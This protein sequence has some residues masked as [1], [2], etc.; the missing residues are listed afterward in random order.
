MGRILKKLFSSLGRYFKKSKKK[1]V[2]LKPKKKFTLR[3]KSKK[4]QKLPARDQGALIGEVTHFFNKIQVIVVKMTRDNLRVGDK[5]RIQGKTTDF[6][7]VVKSLQ[8]ESV[9]VKLVKK[10]QLVGL[11][12]E[13]LAKQGDRVY[14]LKPTLRA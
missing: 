1:R 4:V 7:Q 13:R 5:I 14:K 6:I 12:V 11:K 2:S 3:H 8:I 10:G 9:D